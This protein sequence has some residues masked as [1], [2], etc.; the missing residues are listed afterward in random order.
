MA[1]D[2]LGPIVLCMQFFRDSGLSISELLGVKYSLKTTV[3][4]H[5]LVYSIVAD[6]SCEHLDQ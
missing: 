4:G 1:K 5:A 3:K 6:D 2:V